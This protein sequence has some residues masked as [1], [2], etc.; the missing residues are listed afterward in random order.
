MKDT[1]FDIPLIVRRTRGQKAFYL[2]FAGLALVFGG[3]VTVIFP[4]ALPELF[5]PLSVDNLLFLLMYLAAGPAIILY[6]GPI[7]LRTLSMPV[8]APVMEISQA[9]LVIHIDVVSRRL[10]EPI[11][12]A[13]SD[14][15]SIRTGSGSKNFK[16]LLVTTRDGRKIKLMPH[17]TTPS[18]T[19]VV[20]AMRDAARRAGFDAERSRKFLLFVDY[21]TWTFE[22][23]QA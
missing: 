14:I 19:E 7:Y 10:E 21:T 9:G 20:A 17:L 12:L 15:Q 23:N 8:D 1:N 2:I 18:K 16:E 13:W 4:T 22:P 3:I 6:G 11:V 5:W